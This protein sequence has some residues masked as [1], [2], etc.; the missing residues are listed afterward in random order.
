MPLL[1]IVRTPL[2]SLQ[3][4]VT[5]LDVGKKIRKTPIMVRNCTG[6]VVNRMFFPYTQAALLLVDHGI[7]VYEIDQACTKFGMPKGPFR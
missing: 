6:F 7:D 2:T 5:L 4:V 3:A 1:E